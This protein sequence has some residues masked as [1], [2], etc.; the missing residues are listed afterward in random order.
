ML[1]QRVITA[2][3]LVAALFAAAAAGRLALDAALAV[4]LGAA[5]FEW[6]RLAQHPRTVCVVAAAAFAAALLAGHVAGPPLAG[7]V[8]LAVLAAACC[9]WL[10]I[11]ALV[12]RGAQ[13]GA[14][15]AH[16]V[17]T[18]LAFL[19]LAAAWLALMQLI[20]RGFVYLL[21]VLVLV[22]LA[23]IAAYFAGRRWG[24]RKLAP[25]ISPGKTWAGVGGAVAAVLVVAVAF[26]RL[27]PQVPAFSTLLQQRLVVPVAL[28]LLAALVAL[29]II[30]DLFESLL[31]RQVDAKDSGRLLPG[32]GGVLDRIDALIAVL[33]AAALIDLW[34]RR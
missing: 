25:A 9:A 32:H 19:L 14:R 33:P 6:L 24:R 1:K 12:L 11:A 10:L 20:D 7:E 13:R 15:I 30:G 29:S 18:L 27:A 23:D 3:A 8:L 5:A 34:L 31:K 4:L 16:A 17:S 22:W 26:A 2:I 28:A 21:S